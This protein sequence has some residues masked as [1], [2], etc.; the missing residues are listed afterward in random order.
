MVDFAKLVLQVDSTQIEKGEIALKKLAATGAS[1]EGATKKLGTA[2]KTSAAQLKN[3]KAAAE[4]L[5]VQMKNS[6]GHATN[7]GYQLNDIGVML[8]AG[9]S[10]LLLAFQQGTQVS[11]VFNQMGGGTNALKG[12]SAAFKSVISPM[13]IATLGVN[14]L[15]YT[16]LY[17]AQGP[18]R[19]ANCQPVCILIC[20]V[21]WSLDH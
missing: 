12:L 9:Q 4:K 17:F 18:N 6:T 15:D 19:A 1:A 16:R 11:Q 20:A 14:I 10:P 5:G 21:I 2:A 3:A 8:A 7:L 13:S